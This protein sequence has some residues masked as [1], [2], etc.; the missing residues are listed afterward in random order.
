M[1]LTLG[2]IAGPSGTS[3]NI[4]G[5][6]GRWRFAPIADFDTIAAKV[7]MTTATANAELVVIS[8][9]HTFLVGKGFW[10]SYMTRDSGK[11]SFKMNQDRDT[12]GS[13][14]TAECMIPG[15]D[16][17]IEAI[18]VQ[19]ANNKLITLWELAD[20]RW[21]QLGTERFPAEMKYEWNSENNE[22]G[23]RGWKV[24][25]TAF[26]STKVYYEGAQTLAP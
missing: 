23:E 25:V 14:A 21:I 3:Q 4:G 2:N 5:L 19:A 1:A 8:D 10:E 22:K 17:A 24:T 15:A 16:P 9:D 11:V 20:G 26:E 18:V 6:T 12:T 7:E 13:L